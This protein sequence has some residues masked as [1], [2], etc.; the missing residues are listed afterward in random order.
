MSVSKK[1]ELDKTRKKT[2]RI[3]LAMSNQKDHIYTSI[4]VERKNK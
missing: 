2:Y 3:F 1:K 4:I